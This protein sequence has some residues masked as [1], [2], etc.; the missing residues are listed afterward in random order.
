M[1]SLCQNTLVGKEV[2]CQYLPASGVAREDATATPGIMMSPDK[3]MFNVPRSNTLPKTS[4]LTTPSISSNTA[5][6]NSSIT[7][8]PLQMHAKKPKQNRKKEEK[9]EMASLIV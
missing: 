7:L 3:S 6:S 4:P 8:E 2:N 9:E 5:A 1:G